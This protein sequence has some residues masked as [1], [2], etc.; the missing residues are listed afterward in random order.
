MIYMLIMASLIAL[1]PI[2]GP[3]IVLIVLFAKGIV[4]FSVLLANS[5]IQDGHGLLPIMG[6]SMDDAVKIKAFNFVVG[7]GLGLILLLFGL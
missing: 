5:I 4:P 7:F 3:N 1:L 6:F 2:S